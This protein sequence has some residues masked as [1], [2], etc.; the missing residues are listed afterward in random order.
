MLINLLITHTIST[1]F[2]LHLNLL[3]WFFPFRAAPAAYGSYRAGGRTR[4]TAAGLCHS[5]S[6]ARSKPWLWPTPQLMATPDPDP[7]SE[8]RDR[9]YILMDTSQIRFGCTTMGTSNL[10]L[11]LNDTSKYSFVFCFLISCHSF[12][13]FIRNRIVLASKNKHFFESKSLFKPMIDF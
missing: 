5:H 2:Y 10:H 7:L 1:S 3:L 11:N 12:N 4:A 13:Y 9:T 6:N 8:A